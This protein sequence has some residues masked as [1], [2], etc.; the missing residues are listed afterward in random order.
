MK[1]FV[2][3]VYPHDKI[4]LI[5][6]NFKKSCRTCVFADEIIE[7]ANNGFETRLLKIIREKSKIGYLVKCGYWLQYAGMQYII[8]VSDPKDNTLKNHDIQN[9]YVPKLIVKDK[10]TLLKILESSGLKQ[11]TF[12]EIEEEMKHKFNYFG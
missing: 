6:P 11:I 7:K 10:K 4:E 8:M 5:D 1:K 3:A 12:E 2:V 9:C